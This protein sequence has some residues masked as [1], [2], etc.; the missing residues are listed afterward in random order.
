[1]DGAGCAVARHQAVTTCPQR[2]VGRSELTRPHAGYDVV[3]TSRRRRDRPMVLLGSV[4]APARAG[5]VRHGG[6]RRLRGEL[7]L[8]L[9]G[10]CEVTC[11]EPSR[12]PGATTSS[13]A[14][15]TSSTCR[16][17]RPRWSA[18]AGR[19]LRAA[20]G[21]LRAAAGLPATAPPRTCP[22]SCAAPAGE[23][24]GQQLLLAGGVRGRPADRLRGAHPGRQLVVLPAAQ[25]RRGASGRERSRRSTTSRSPTA[26]PVRGWPTS[27]S[28]ATRTAD[29]PIDV[30]AE[31]RSG[32]V[33]LVP[34]GWHGPSMA[35]PGYDLYYLNVMAGP[36]R[37][38]PG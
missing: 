6:D 3:V 14:S 34:H 27:G 11:E 10:S 35:A 9:A 32:D 37:S 20:L 31:V 18:P 17:R 4:G 21:G 16:V 38:G 24:P 19:P 26:P 30:L 28:T 33:V 12:S 2:H 29:R 5:G 7:V 36:A 22:S 1:M 23:P 15:A 13:A 25:A 8:S